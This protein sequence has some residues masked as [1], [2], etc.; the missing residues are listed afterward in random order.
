METLKYND[1]LTVLD[2][3]GCNLTEVGGVAVGEVLPG[4]KGLRA[5][6]LGGNSIGPVGCKVRLLG[7]HF[8]V[9]L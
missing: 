9:R 6:H 2:V 1:T 7:R 8:A 4:V 5:L 3:S